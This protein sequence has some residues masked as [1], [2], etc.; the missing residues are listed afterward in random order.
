MEGNQYRLLT[1]LT[2]EEQLSVVIEGVDF[3][4]ADRKDLRD[5]LLTKR[6]FRHCNFEGV[7]L[8]EEQDFSVISGTAFIDCKL[9]GCMIRFRDHYDLCFINC[10]PAP[11]TIQE[12]DC[13]CLSR[14][15]RLRRKERHYEKET[16]DRHSCTGCA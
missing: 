11:E 3:S 4:K 6:I 12:K 1:D 16:S 14:I 5:I 10:S 13:R 2:K 7:S 8:D 15:R 9:D